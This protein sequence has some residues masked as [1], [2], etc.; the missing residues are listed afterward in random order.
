[1]KKNWLELLVEVSAGCA[2][3]AAARIIEAGA[4]AVEEREGE[5]GAALLVTHVAAGAGATKKL[6]A[7]E[8][9][10]ADLGVT[11]SAFTLKNIEE[12]DWVARARGHFGGAAYGERLWV[13]PSWEEAATPPGRVALL[14]EPGLAFGTGRH[15]STHLAL[16]AIEERCA[17]NPPERVVDL[18]C[19]SGIL[20]VAALLLGAGRVTALDL[21]P[22]AV[23]ETIALAEKN[24]VGEK[25]TVRNEALTP[26][27]LG[28]WWGRVDFL[29]A[30][31]F[32]DAL[33]EL[34]PRI[35]DALAPGGEGVLSGIGYE[36]EENLAR[37]CRE[38]GLRVRRTRRIEEWASVEVARS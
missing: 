33:V 32:L 20:G 22:A 8:N 13:R 23:D 7:I 3:E 35:R 29:A 24:G 34:A 27:A 10:L 9:L 37:T 26:G 30:N 2:E 21:D 38:A 17:P 6:R 25:I 1:M 11:K 28:N 4:S 19:G 16:L 15:P 12:H 18:G 14:L 36:Q 5:R 31:I